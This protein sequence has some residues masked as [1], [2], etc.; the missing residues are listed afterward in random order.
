MAL[1]IDFRIKGLVRLLVLLLLLLLLPASATEDEK[2]NTHGRRILLVHS[3]SIERS[4]ETDVSSSFMRS[5]LRL[6]A[7]PFVYYQ[8]E[9]HSDVWPDRIS[10][11]SLLPL[12]PSLE[13]GK[14]AAVITIGNKAV[15]IIEK[16]HD[17]IPESTFIYN[18]GVVT[19]PEEEK[20]PLQISG[21]A[22]RPTLRGTLELAA[23]L[24]PERRDFI[25]LTDDADA[26][27]LTPDGIRQISSVVPGIN[28]HVFFCRKTSDSEVIDFIK[29]HA[30][31]AIVFFLRWSCRRNGPD[32]VG[33]ISELSG[34]ARVPIFVT[35]RSLITFGAIG[36]VVISGRDIGAA[37]AAD[38]FAALSGQS[39]GNNAA[40]HRNIPPRM[41]LD[42]GA[43]SSFNVPTDLIP[44]DAIIENRPPSWW[45]VYQN[46]FLLIAGL[47]FFMLAA[48]L[49]VVMLRMIRH[50]KKSEEYAAK[51]KTALEDAHAA[52]RAKTDF[53]S[54]MSHEIRTPLNTV[55][56]FSELL[57]DDSL[58]PDERFDYLEAIQ[59]S[60]NALL[61]LINDILDL[62]KLDA[63]RLK[64]KNDSTNLGELFHEIK[65]IF[66]RQSKEK[67]IEFKVSLPPAIPSV[68]TD[69]VR[70]RQIIL[71]LVGNA[72]KF[73]EHGSI[74]L[75]GEYA[76]AANGAGVLTIRVKDTGIGM[77]PEFLSKLFQPFTQANDEHS[78]AK[79][80]GTGLGLSISMRLAKAMNGV[81]KAESVYGKGS[82]FTLEL[83]G[84]ATSS[85]RDEQTGENKAA[86]LDSLKYSILIVDDQPL[87]LTVLD[88]MLRK[89]GLDPVTANSGRK[90]LKLFERTPF[91]IVM[92][93]LKM[94]KMSGCDLA[95]AIRDI[96]GGKDAKIFVVTADIYA[97]TGHNLDSFDGVLIKPLTLEKLNRLFIA[98][99]KRKNAGGMLLNE[100][101]SNG[102]SAAK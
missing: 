83:A 24:F 31:D 81:L 25:I 2:D 66:S 5:M 65:A 14:F 102:G 9:L 56:G 82:C 11:A 97:D 96:P 19:A 23:A 39:G 13:A 72:F 16:H 61:D 60:S 36:G 67:K 79:Q 8:V 87:N 85:V 20:L 75:S 73:T 53:L 34:T 40:V 101:H 57:R 77:R 7:E 29:N 10:D 99:N 26:D 90:A 88:R 28:L 68:M 84:V 41:I 49:F 12:L 51:L 38:V 71:N 86:L 48:L 50:Q 58:P 59:F 94:P 46:E 37:A 42:W 52:D 6:T 64:I 18:M 92:T 1:D 74:E 93:D 63:G 70:L 45:T 76:P 98:V 69:P 54:T 95:A 15:E 21:N 91:D 55:I 44:T 89:F 62:A 3:S 33:M 35:R 43:L 4:R 27:Q 80:T 47:I 22:I 100:L 17:K 32:E 78:N 30:E